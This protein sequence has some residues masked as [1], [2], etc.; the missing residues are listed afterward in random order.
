MGR[1][2]RIL[3]VDDEQIYL[4]VFEAVLGPHGYQ[5]VLVQNGP[6]ALAA[7]RKEPI[8]LVILDV[9]MPGMNGFEV[10]GLIKRDEL[11]RHIPVVMITACDAK[12]RRIQGINAGA[13]EFLSKPFDASEVLARVA[14]LLK[15]K[16]LHDQLATA[17]LHIN[18]L[19]SY[20]QHLTTTFDPLH[21]DVMAGV[22]SIV[23]QLIISSS[24]A[25]DNPQLV[26][27]RL[28]QAGHNE[29]YVC[30]LDADHNLILEK[31]TTEVCPILRALVGTS[32]V[33][34]LNP[35]DLANEVGTLLQAVLARQGVVLANLVCHVSE[36]ITLCA[37][38]YG[39]K[40]TRHDA[41]VLNS[42]A[43]QTIFFS[44]LA[45]QVRETEDAFTYM[46]SS[47]ARAAEANDDDTGEHIRRVGE[48][49]ALLASRMGLAEEFVRLIRLQGVMHDVGKI[50]I[51]AAILKKPGPLLASEFEVMQQHCLT[52]ATIIGDHVRLTM[53][54]EI[55]LCHHER[56]DGS[57]YPQ[58]LAG[59]EIPLSARILNLADQYDALR[60]R[61]CYKPAFDHE[62]ACR[63][64]SVGDGRTRPE[65]FDPQVLRAF[66]EVAPLFAETYA[67]SLG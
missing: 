32:Q 19:L 44:S 5:T 33:A 59:E 14:M 36:T 63:I 53:A 45:T 40:V 49:S 41:E 24:Q 10:C 18:S 6:D 47:L 23:K 60:N 54:K 39:R 65:H 8:D 29:L 46:V 64:I 16:G 58:G 9:V 1:Q 20:G 2:P 38:N 30:Q 25:S 42:V 50:H 22:G 66:L 62:A 17:Y 55:A 43:T 4:S 31:M 37:M 28:Q 26:L 56:Y 3:C 34:W 27:V 67:A 15:V 57:G 61:R 21:Y 13:E 52:G 12:N 35:A 48:Y 7:L 51:P 11:L